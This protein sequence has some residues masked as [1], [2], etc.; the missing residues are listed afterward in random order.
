MIGVERVD[1]IGV[2]VND[3]A[4]ADAY[5]GD[6][7][8]LFER[9]PRSTERWVEYETGNVT[10]ALVPTEYRSGEHEPLPFASVV[11]RVDDVGEARKKLQGRGVE[12][13]RETLRLRGLQ[14]G[15]FPD[16]D[17]NGLMLHHRY[18][19]FSDGTPSEAP[20]GDESTSWRSRRRTASGPS[21]FYSRHAR[22]R[23]QRARR[24]TWARVRDRERDARHSSIRR[25]HRAGVQATS[26]RQG[27]HCASMTSRRPGPSSRSQ[28]VQFRRRHDRHRRLQ[29]WPRSRIRTGTR[30]M[31]H[32][33]Y[34]PKAA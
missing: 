32:R 9:S 11:V 2:P 1:F 16:P 3:L 12:F 34:G 17:G 13:V 25:R 4:A 7:L 22:P 28:G 29:A 27:S 30:L 5:Y 18:A 10:L 31:L 6:T 33:R 23:S 8:D 26:R 24:T 15:A 14:H 20:S 21:E 19:P